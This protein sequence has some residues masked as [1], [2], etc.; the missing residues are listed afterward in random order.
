MEHVRDVNEEQFAEAVVARSRQVPVVVDFW[1]GWCAPCRMLGP[2]LEREVAALGGRVELVKI[3]VDQNQALSQQFDVKG[4]PAVKAFRDGEVVAEFSGARDAGFVRQF[5]TELSPSADAQ[6]L[7]GAATEAELR[8]LID[9][10][11]V[12]A[13]ARLRL[14]Q[15]VLSTGRAEEAK[16]LLDAIPPSAREAYAQAQTLGQL[17]GLALA[18]AQF[19]GEAKARAAVAANEGD[20]D[21]RYALGC[22]LASAGTFEA[23]LEAFLEVVARKKTHQDGAA[24][25]AMVL[26]FEVLGH[27][28]PLTRD[29]RRRLQIVL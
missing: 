16:A 5:L 9:S 22:A 29:F 17:V 28:H 24:R 7:Q 19:G 27:E 8:A 12:G 2:V 1:A 18:A 20:L 14:A 13:Q 10:A 21:A 4:I 25:K 15:L 23:A 11:D 26:L 6:A 3:D